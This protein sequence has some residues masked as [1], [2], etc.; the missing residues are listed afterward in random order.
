MGIEIWDI[1]IQNKKPPNLDKET[2]KENH[3]P[4]W[5]EQVKNLST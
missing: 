2:G 1:K 5:D 3:E 4:E